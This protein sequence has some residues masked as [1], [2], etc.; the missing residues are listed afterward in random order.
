MSQAIA[1]APIA[2]AEAPIFDQGETDESPSPVPK[3][4]R[5][6]EREAATNAPPMTGGHDTPEE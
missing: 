1:P 3:V 4:S 5:M 2:E 6:R